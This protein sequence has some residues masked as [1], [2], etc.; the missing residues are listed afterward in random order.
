M[1]TDPAGEEHSR[2]TSAL[3]EAYE[4]F[5]THGVDTHRQ[6]SEGPNP[7]LLR[8]AHDRMVEMK[9]QRGNDSWREFLGR[10]GTAQY[11]VL[12]RL[13][14]AE[15]FDVEDYWRARELTNWWFQWSKS[16][17]R[18]ERVREARV[19]G[20]PPPTAAALIERDGTKCWRCRRKCEV[21]PREAF[22]EVDPET[23][24]GI[25]RNP[26][27]RTVG[28]VVQISDGGKDTMANARLECWECNS[29]DGLPGLRFM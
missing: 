5:L 6:F 1:S 28:H 17:R 4:R 12:D 23:G 21:D 13:T 8:L 3:D 18:A 2:S 24:R 26:R 29:A 9:G 14:G 20:E 11:R 7:S 16:R 10:I 22:I 25:M 27:Y 15:G 19:P